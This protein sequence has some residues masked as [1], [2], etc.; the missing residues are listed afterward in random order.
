MIATVVTRFSDRSEASIE[1]DVIYLV[2]P[3][4]RWLVAKPDSTLY[5]AVGIADVPV[6]AL[7]PQLTRRDARGSPWG[8]PRLKPNRRGGRIAAAPRPKGT[9]LSQPAVQTESKT[10]VGA[11][12]LRKVFGG[13]EA[14]VTA[15]DGVACRVP[16][17][18]RSRRSWAR[19]ARASR[20]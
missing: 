11:A 12:G 15:L 20:R 8:D 1:D 3:Q 5:R 6:G 7:T 14:G 17:P 13:G 16:E 10:I 19:P 4:G 18:A 9:P 2:R